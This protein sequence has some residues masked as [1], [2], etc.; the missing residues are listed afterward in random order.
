MP[1]TKLANAQHHGQAGAPN[2]PALIAY[3]GQILAYRSLA[4][5]YIVTIQNLFLANNSGSPEPIWMKFYSDEA[6]MEGF[7]ENFGHPEMAQEILNF[8]GIKRLR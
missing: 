2:L 8:T 5:A 3:K 7:P 1:G 4:S 6:Q